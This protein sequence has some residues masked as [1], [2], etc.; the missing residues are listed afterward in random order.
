MDETGNANT[1]NE[2]S[3][4]DGMIRAEKIE[5]VAVRLKT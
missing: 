5:L 1:F 3:Q 2:N 4:C